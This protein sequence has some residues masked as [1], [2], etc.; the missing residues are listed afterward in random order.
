MCGA[1]KLEFAM[2]GF[3]VDSLSS[4]FNFAIFCLVRTG[5]EGASGGA[6]DSLF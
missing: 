1:S 3:R 6:V 2:M 5:D 4:F